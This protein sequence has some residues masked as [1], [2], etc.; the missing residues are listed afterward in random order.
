MNS[1]ICPT[2]LFIEGRDWKNETKKEHFT[3]TLSELLDFIKKTGSRIYWND[4]LEELLWSNPDLYPWY[5]S[6]SYAISEPLHQCIS[7]LPD[8][9]QFIPCLCSPEIECNVS[10]ADIVS[11]TLSLIHYLFINKV[12]FDFLV[13]E[14][15]CFNFVFSCSCHNSILYSPNIVNTF[16]VPIDISKE[17]NKYWDILDEHSFRYI[18]NLVASK[19]FSNIQHMISHL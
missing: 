11:P 4:I 1:V 8:S 9:I 14:N 10:K 12:N 3:K 6:N 17:I 18:I 7:D 5:D 2:L 13:D 16:I 19:Y 15:N